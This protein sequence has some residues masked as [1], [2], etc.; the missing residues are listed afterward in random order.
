MPFY[1]GFKMISGGKIRPPMRTSWSVS[2]FGNNFAA[3][4]YGI[5]SI[6]KK[7]LRFTDSIVDFYRSIKCCA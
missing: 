2:G 5:A 6:F 1:P 7:V 3:A 4:R